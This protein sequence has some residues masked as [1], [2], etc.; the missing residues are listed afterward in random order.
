MCGGIIDIEPGQ[1]ITIKSPNFPNN[2]ET[3]SECVWLLR[4]SMVVDM[5]GL[6]NKIH[7]GC[8]MLEM[9]YLTQS[10]G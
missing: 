9:H 7:N 6:R 8:S 4:V 10:G 5:L 1:E 3:N 2:Y